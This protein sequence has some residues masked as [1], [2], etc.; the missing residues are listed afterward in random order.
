LAEFAERSLGGQNQMRLGFCQYECKGFTYAFAS[1]GN[2]DGLM[3]KR[4]HM[5][6]VITDRRT[7]PLLAFGANKERFSNKIATSFFY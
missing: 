3:G 5:L 1:A 4:G 2:D 7:S 6:G